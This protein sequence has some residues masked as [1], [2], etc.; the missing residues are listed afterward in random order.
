MIRT[1]QL[2]RPL[3]ALAL[4]ACAAIGF[5]QQQVQQGDPPARVASLS[6]I[7]G[8]VA[9]APPGET[10]WADAGLNRPITQGDRLWVDR[11]SRA[12]LHMGSSVL[13]LDGQTFLDVAALDD[14]VMQA[15]LNDGTVNARVRDL[16]PGENFEIDTPQLAF[17]A[18]QPGDYRI[19]VDAKQGTTRVTVRSGAALVFGAGGQ[20]QQLRAGQEA[21]F[22][23]QDLDRIALPAAADN[24][25][26]RWAQA[27]NRLEDQS[28]TARYV[29]RD[30]VG[31]Q[32]LDAYGSWAQDATYGAVWY[33]REVAVDWAPYRYGHWDFIAPWGWTWVDD[34]PWG[35]APFHYGRWAQ[36]GTRWAWVP[37]R[38][39]P[40]PV[41]APALVAFVGGNGGVDWS[42]SFGSNPGIGW[43]PLGPGEAWRPTYRASS[44]YL[45]NVNRYVAYGN[46][47]PTT[48]VHQHRPNAWTSVRVE[49][50]SRGR[51]VHNSWQ[52]V[53]AG[54]IGRAQIVNQPSALP[55]P[56]RF[57]ENNAPAR[58]RSLPPPQAMQP[59]ATPRAQPIFQGQ[60][61]PRPPVAEQ[62]SVQPLAPPRMQQERPV[63]QPRQPEALQ[64]QQQIRQQQA[65]E[66]AI[67]QQQRQQVQEQRQQA[68][69]QRQLQHQRDA[70]AAAAR[71]AQPMPQQPPRA[72]PPPPAQVH[73]QVQQQQ[74]PRH[75]PR[76]QR[77]RPQPDPGEKGNGNGPDEQ[78]RGRGHNRGG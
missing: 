15:S 68:Q 16:Q 7:E 51:P 57:V 43:F 28:V 67:Q 10:E 6:Q 53:R 55:P 45:S 5:A 54:E 77:V 70:E 46:R 32:Q 1:R 36:V 9:Y 24:G 37:G 38:L 64:Q 47:Y 59:A 20:P 23:G 29:P 30:V 66:R 49:D 61:G 35:F 69:E 58:L 78:G 56:R 60:A 19:D 74:A 2:I 12:E 41:Y 65:Q 3:L 75:E 76:E 72:M 39:G 21:A 63:P 22:T 25:F 18:T 27:R 17:R 31:Y 13:H 50:F 14:D 8:S 11:G 40:R 4:A 26:D 42:I 48:Y 52:P 33:P 73:P 71:R 44:I 34:A 62:R